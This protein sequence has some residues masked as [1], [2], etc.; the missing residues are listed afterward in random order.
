M[1]RAEFPPDHPHQPAGGQAEQEKQNPC[2]SRE[3][4][5]KRAAQVQPQREFEDHQPDGA[6]GRLPERVAQHDARVAGIELV[7]DIQPEADRDP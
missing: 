3:Q 2:I 7:V 6:V 1:E 4:K 5:E